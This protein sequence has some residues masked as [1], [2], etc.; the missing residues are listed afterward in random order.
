M[1]LLAPDE[2]DFTAYLKATEAQQKVR[3]ASVWLD[4]IKSE[5]ISPP[6]NDSV[7]MP[8][9]CTHGTFAFRAGEVTIYAGNNGG[10]KSLLTGQVAMGLIK[11]GQKICV[12]SF[13]MKPKRSL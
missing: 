11:Q 9:T 7:V 13:E 4:D 5:V 2:I 6:V 1:N 12:A 8:W 10:G 3:E